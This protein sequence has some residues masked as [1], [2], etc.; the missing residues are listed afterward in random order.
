MTV[1]Q[2]LLDLLPPA[3][4]PLDMMQLQKNAGDSEWPGAG[5]TVQQREGEAEA[6]GGKAGRGILALSIVDRWAAERLP[7]HFLSLTPAEI[8]CSHLKL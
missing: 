2:N 6:A 7:L 5:L 1:A 3:R 4:F 8:Q